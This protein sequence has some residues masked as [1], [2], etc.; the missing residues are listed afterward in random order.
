M[1]RFVGGLTM[2]KHQGAGNDFLIMV[3]LDDQVRLTSDEVAQLCDRHLG[4]GAD[5][6]ITVTAGTG[7]GEVTMR[8]ANADGSAAEISGNGLRC[9]VHEVV[10]SGIVAPGAFSVMTAAGLRQ[11]NCAEPDGVRAWTSADMGTLDLLSLDAAARTAEISVG[12]PHLVMVVDDLAAV[13]AARD[14]AALQ[15]RRN[16][17]I[18]VEGIVVD[19]EG[20]VSLKVFERGVGPTLACG[21]GSCAAALAARELGLVGN[22]VMVHNPGGTLE[23]ALEGRIATLSGEVQVIADLLVPLERMR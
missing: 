16:G 1:E 21:S 4:L 22:E 6:V 2:S 17:G 9:L 20:G 12:N 8:L 19:G 5:G 18:N 13:D 14:G 23:V 7:G 15:D 11:V 10:R 3:D